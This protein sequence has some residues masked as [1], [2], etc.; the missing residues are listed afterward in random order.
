MPFW[1]EMFIAK[2]SLSLHPNLITQ[3]RFTLE[4]QKIIQRF[5]NY[6]KSFSHENFP[7]NIEM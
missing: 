1:P 3:E 5:C 2:H 6:T 4:L 7:N